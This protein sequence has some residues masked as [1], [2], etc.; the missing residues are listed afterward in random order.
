MKGT[1]KAYFAITLQA[2]IVG[3]SFLAVKIALRSTNTTDLLAHRFTLAA[4]SV[5]IYG[6]VKRDEIRF[7]L[8]DWLKIIPLGIFYP[9]FFFLFQTL[10]LEI[11][12]SSEAGIIYAIAPILTLIAARILLNE[13][14]NKTQ[15]FLML[16]SVSGV[17][18]IHTMNGFNI[19]GYSYF[20][21]LFILLSAVSFAVYNVFAKNFLKII[22]YL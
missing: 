18:Y 17:I 8:S 3:F 13:K 5:L 14:V 22:L 1:T 10:G 19:G 15:K 11:I 20:G 2:L 16:V 4:L 6:F 12:S 21:F 9:I 7:R